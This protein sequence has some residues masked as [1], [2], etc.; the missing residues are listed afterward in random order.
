MEVSGSSGSGSSGSGSSGSGSSVLLESQTGSV[1]IGVTGGSW[2]SSRFREEFTFPG[3]GISSG[4]SLSAP[5]R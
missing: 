4:F 5:T 3:K 2:F 1:Y